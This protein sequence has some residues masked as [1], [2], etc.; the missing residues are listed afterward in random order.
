VAA[1][2]WKGIADFM[3][4]LTGGEGLTAIIHPSALYIMGIAA[5]L[6]IV[7]ELARIGTKNKSPIVPVALGLGMV[8]PPD[9]TFWMFLGSL[10]FWVMGRMY[11]AKKESFGHRLWVDT[12]E[13]ICA[14][15]IA[16]AAL[17][18]IGGILVDV[19]LLPMLG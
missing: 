16:G 17:V 11:K 1:V 13:P 19:F 9:S 8:L 14:G 2:Q 15:L 5:V 6:G 4:G 10:F 18:G 12:H 7:L 3:R